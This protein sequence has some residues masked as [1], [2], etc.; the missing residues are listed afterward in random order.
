MYGENKY[1]ELED[2]SSLGLAIKSVSKII[3]ED[4]MQDYLEDLM[5]YRDNSSLE[6]MNE[7]GVK[8]LFQNALE[9]S[10]AFSMIKRCGLNPN[11]YFTQ[12]DFTSILAFDSY[13]TITRIGVA[14]SEISEMGL[15]E[16][17]N[18][19]KNL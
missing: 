4:N 6:A 7:E 1:G 8:L 13:D 19:I 10:V 2:K 14:T 11:K 12:E 5:F 9:N 16:I 3:V 15:R 17:Y 18:I